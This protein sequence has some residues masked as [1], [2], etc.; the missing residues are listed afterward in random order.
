MAACTACGYTHSHIQHACWAK[1][2]AAHTRCE[3]APR[4]K[5]GALHAHIEHD[6][7]SFKEAPKPKFVEEPASLALALAQWAKG[8]R[9]KNMCSACPE[10]HTPCRACW[11]RAGYKAEHYTEKQP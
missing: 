6:C 10:L 4:C 3:P 11:V 2:V 8:W 1:P 9:P 5:C 7:S